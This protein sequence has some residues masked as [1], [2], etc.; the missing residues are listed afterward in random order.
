MNEQ[1]DSNEIQTTNECPFT[2]VYIVLIQSSFNSNGISLR[3]FHSPSDFARVNS[4]FQLLN[5]R[6]WMLRPNKNEQ[7]L[8][9]FLSLSFSL[10]S[11]PLKLTE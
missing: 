7:R 4:K 6:K 3:T 2:I 5:L 11:S 8:S 9:P 10:R 1:N